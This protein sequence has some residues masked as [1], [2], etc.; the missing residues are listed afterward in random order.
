LYKTEGTTFKNTN[1]NCAK[2]DQSSLKNCSFEGSS[3]D[4]ASFS[5]AVLR[6]CSFTDANI[7]YVNW[8]YS[9]FILPNYFTSH[10]NLLEKKIRTLCTTGNGNRGDYQNADLKQRQFKNETHQPQEL[11]EKGSSGIV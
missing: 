11:T 5:Y 1:L 2:F 8:R 6:K 3:L 9:Q 10:C 4:H 7:S